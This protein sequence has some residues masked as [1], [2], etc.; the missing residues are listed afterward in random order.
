MTAVEIQIIELVNV[1][2]GSFW[3]LSDLQDV[4]I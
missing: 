3:I 2:Y 4:I 1:L